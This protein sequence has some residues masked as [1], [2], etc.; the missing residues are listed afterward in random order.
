[1][2]R[3]L[4]LFT[5]GY[6]Y[7]YRDEPF[8]E[9]EIEYL[10]EAF[11][12]I[13]IFPKSKPSKDKRVTPFNVE[14]N[15]CINQAE[16]KNKKLA[17]L[18]NLFFVLKI[19]LPN[20]YKP[21]NVISFWKNFKLLS[22]ILA[23]GIIRGKELKKELKNI[24]LSNTVFYDY[25]FTNSFY[26]ISYLKTH[27]KIKKFVCRGHRYDIYKENWPTNDVPFFNY[28]IKNVDE[29]YLISKHGFN[30]LK[31]LSPRKY[32]VKLKLSYLGVI[33]HNTDQV[34]KK[35]S[36]E[37]FLI[38]SC[39]RVI[40][41]KRVHEIPLILKNIKSQ[42]KWVHFGDGPLFDKLKESCKLLPSNIEVDL[43][44]YVS[45]EEVINYYKKN[46]IDLF[47]SISLSEGLPVSMMEALSFGMPIISKDVG[48]IREIVN[49][50]T[51]LLL[52][53]DASNNEISLKIIELIEKRKFN[54]KNIIDFYDRCFNADKNFS[55]FVE[56]ICL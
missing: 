28:R 1:M 13:V 43:R 3:T 2:K 18:S 30:H 39:A 19:V 46:K 5:A 33:N 56:Q 40:D 48:G 8:L 41:F 23:Q 26:S 37:K 16:L 7:G 38:V 47:F 42:V 36:E 20:A 50:T 27:R 51:G 52:K 14:V 21:Q 15:D 53:E 22:D 9:N 55:I 44:G 25:W 6:P 32:W 17:I 35:N 34:I 29:L 24:D 4:Y 12:K 10:A 11:D 49:E 45:N 31:A 54:T